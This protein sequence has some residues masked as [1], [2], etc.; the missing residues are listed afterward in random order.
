M[1]LQFH[2]IDIQMRD[3][4]ERI[5]TLLVGTITTTTT[6]ITI[7]I[8]TGNV[9]I[10][11]TAIST[12]ITTEVL[13]TTITTDGITTIIEGIGMAIKRKIIQTI[14]ITQ[15]TTTT[16]RMEAL[17]VWDIIGQ[18]QINIAILHCIARASTSF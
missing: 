14:R 15:I 11:T 17:V 10:I 16:I 3:G 12:L 4:G 7:T 9:K 5:T 1:G 18:I 13:I 8:K 2:G 6:R